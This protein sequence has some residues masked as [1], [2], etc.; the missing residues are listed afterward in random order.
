MRHRRILLAASV[1]LAAGCKSGDLTLDEGTG[2]ACVAAGTICSV[3]G[4][5]IGDGGDWS[6]ALFGRPHSWDRAADGTIWIS[7]SLHNRIR[8]IAPDGRVETV[9]GGKPAREGEIRLGI[10]PFDARVYRPGPITICPDGTLFF[11]EQDNN[12]VYE[13]PPD[14]GLLRMGLQDIGPFSFGTHID[15]DA[16]GNV[17]LAT[18]GYLSYRAWV[19]NRGTTDLLVA[20]Q[21][22]APGAVGLLAGTETTT[23]QQDGIPATAAALYYPNQV[24][25]GA[26]PLIATAGRIRAINSTGG[27]YTFAG[28]GSPGYAGDGGPY[29]DA[30]L[31]EHTMLDAG[32]AVFL[33]DSAYG[34]DSAR[35]R[36]LNRGAT[37][38]TFAGVTVAAGNIDTVAGG[39]A[40]LLGADISGPALQQK[41]NY[42][43]APPLMDDDGNLL[44]LDTHNHVIRRLDAASGNMEVVAGFGEGGTPDSWLPAT[45]AV[46]VDGDGSLL[47]LAEAGRLWRMDPRDGALEVVAGT[48]VMDLVGDGG[49]AI[50][51]GF[52]GVTVAAADDGTIYVADRRNY[53]VRAILPDGTIDTVAGTGAS[54]DGGAG[55]GA[56]ALIADLHAPLALTWDESRGVLFL[57]DGAKVRA[58]NRSSSA[59]TVGG[60]TIQPGNIDR[61]AG[62]NTQGYGGDGGPALAATFDFDYSRPN[63]ALVLG[64]A[65]FLTDGHNHRI[66]RIDLTD[67]TIERVA[68]DGGS[69]VDGDGGPPLSADVGYPLSLASDGE[70]LYVGQDWGVVRRFRLDGTGVMEVFAGNG[71]LGWAGDGGLALDANLA[72][73]ASLA[74]GAD[75]T[76]YI[77]DGSHRIRRVAP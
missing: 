30:E 46:T 54:V 50:S 59:V 42:G 20:G 13:L 26:V 22:V 52:Y 41:L 44:I 40:D 9:V 36:L 12:D 63:A 31:G 61:I 70:Y 56:S 14:R 5:S 3:G 73:A 67:G 66:R 15:C 51:A 53:V 17:W 16:D 7:D 32:D 24:L 38:I 37:P 19:W 76:L 64:T 60:V 45:R 25:P 72:R 77:A 27:I 2:L 35:I 18:S 1:A 74:F 68:G 49:P 6:R 57:I 34:D 48:G 43:E 11:A 55:D 33:R 29:V 47:V 69:Y 21:V 23:P 62:Q 71:G 4:S 58:I 65:L 8:R 39:N 28:V 75:G 10:P